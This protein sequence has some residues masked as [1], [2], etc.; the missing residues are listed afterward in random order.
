[1]SILKNPAYGKTDQALLEAAKGAFEAVG[2]IPVE[3]SANGEAVTF[4]DERL[5]VVNAGKDREQVVIFDCSHQNDAL[6]E[7][8]FGENAKQ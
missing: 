3:S 2:P 1:M 8:I 5:T 7:Q 4:D 6:I